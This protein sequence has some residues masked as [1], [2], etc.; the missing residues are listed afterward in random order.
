MSSRRKKAVS[1]PIM[2]LIRVLLE[3]AILDGMVGKVVLCASQNCV[4]DDEKSRHSGS[5]ANIQKGK[6]GRGK[7]IEVGD[8]KKEKRKQCSSSGGRDTE[9]RK[10]LPGWGGMADD[11]ITR[12]LRCAELAWQ[13]VTVWEVYWWRAAG[14]VSSEG[15]GEPCR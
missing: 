1:I 8:I 14:N 13:L 3:S 11:K 5:E 7:K 12:G 10:F 6:P 15:H 9:P 4:G 2:I